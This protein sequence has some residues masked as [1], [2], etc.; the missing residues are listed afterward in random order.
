MEMVPLSQM[1]SHTNS[2]SRIFGFLESFKS[3]LSL[4]KEI[5]SISAVCSVA[6]VASCDNLS[7]S[8]CIQRQPV[9][10]LDPRLST[11]L[12]QQ[13]V[14]FSINRTKLAIFKKRDCIPK[15]FVKVTKTDYIGSRVARRMSLC[16]P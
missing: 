1:N 4:F 6:L 16:R 2:R 14:V 7:V 8:P 11:T 15:T 13:S 10:S 12:I 5:E 9:R 3:Y